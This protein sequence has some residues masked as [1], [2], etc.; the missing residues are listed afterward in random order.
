MVILLSA[1]FEATGINHT[2]QQGG[3]PDYHPI[4]RVEDKNLDNNEEILVDFNGSF[5][6][7]DNK[8][9]TWAYVDSKKNNKHYVWQIFGKDILCSS[10]R[11]LEKVSIEAM[12]K[13]PDFQ[14]GINKAVLQKMVFLK[15]KSK[16]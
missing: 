2:I 11:N 4:I 9:E 8:P 6:H 1:L 3:L 7:G 14:D 16:E 13:H 5:I 12:K 10:H 15:K